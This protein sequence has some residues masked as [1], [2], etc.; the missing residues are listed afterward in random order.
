MGKNKAKPLV[1]RSR[2]RS[3]VAAVQTINVAFF[4]PRRGG[5]ENK[6]HRA[7]DPAFF[8]ILPSTIQ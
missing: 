6:I 8:K 3:D 4:K 5:A 1:S 7:G 2:S